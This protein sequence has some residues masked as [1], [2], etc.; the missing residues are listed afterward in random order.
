MMRKIAFHFLSVGPF[1]M[2]PRND[3]GGQGF[4]P[5]IHQ[6]IDKMRLS[7][8]DDGQ[9]RLGIQ[10]ELTQSVD[11]RED[12]K[13]EKRGF[14]YYEYDLHLLFA[15]KAADFASYVPQKESAR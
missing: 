10:L 4:G 13:P 8:Q 5:R 11:L 9:V 7:R 12:F 2:G 1:E 3:P 14:I 15:H 6:L